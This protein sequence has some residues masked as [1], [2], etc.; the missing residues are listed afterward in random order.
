MSWCEAGGQRISPCSAVHGEYY[1][2]NLVT[3][4]GSSSSWQSGSRS[5][6]GSRSSPP[7]VK[8]K[9]RVWKLSDFDA[10][11]LKSDIE[12]GATVISDA[13]VK[14]TNQFDNIGS[15]KCTVNNGQ[16]PKSQFLANTNESQCQK[17]C[18]KN[19]ACSGYSAATSGNC[20]LWLE[21]PLD[22]NSRYGAQ[23]GGTS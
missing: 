20:L 16:D 13:T 18:R 2:G 23:W 1:N 14:Y 17:A 21:G 11:G 5:S 12:D 9:P 7:P 3:G 8:N 4:S 15:G 10:G 19:N 22:S 6:G